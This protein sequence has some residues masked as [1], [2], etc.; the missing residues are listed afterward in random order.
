MK[1]RI[2]RSDYFVATGFPY[3]FSVETTDFP[4]GPLICSY[5]SSLLTENRPAVSI[6]NLYEKHSFLCYAVNGAYSVVTQ[7]RFI[8]FF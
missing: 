8:T 3:I 7:E 6:I 1:L 4:D 2:C 5:D